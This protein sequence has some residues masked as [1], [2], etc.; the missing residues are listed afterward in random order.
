MLQTTLLFKITKTILIFKF[1]E[2]YFKINKKDYTV[3]TVARQD[4]PL[5]FKQE[6]LFRP[7]L[8][9]SIYY[10]KSEQ[11]NICNWNLDA[12]R[13]VLGITLQASTGL[14]FRM[15]TVWYSTYFHKL[16]RYTKKSQNYFL[17][18]YCITKVW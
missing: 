16:E 10:S 15:S 5:N 18:I 12:D 4:L 13:A 9:T 8:I 17:V 1:L 2:K 6:V 11:N 7:K 14:L 3:N